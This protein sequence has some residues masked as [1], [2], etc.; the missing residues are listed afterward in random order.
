MRWQ[1]S[2][3]GIGVIQFTMAILAVCV[4]VFLAQLSG[5]SLAPL[6]AFPWRLGRGEA[7]RLLSS[8]LLHGGILHFAFNMLWFYRLNQA[9]ERWLGPWTA[10]GLFIFLAVGAGSP[11]AVFGGY[12][13]GAIGASGVV[14]GLFGFLWVCRRR[15]DI[16]AEAVTPP[17]IQTMLAWMGL[18][19]LLNFFGGN[20]ANIAH[21]FGLLFGWLIGQIVVA[22]RNVRWPLIAGTAA[23]WCLL[24]SLTYLPVWNTVTSPIPR[25]H[26]RYGWVDL[27][28]SDWRDAEE[29]L[30]RVRVGTL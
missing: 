30:G 9:I 27:D 7:W 5:T 12:S 28:E 11:Q 18:C 19:F 1:E 13:I 16:A 29:K 4:A 8:T 26:E 17:V 22:T 24:L 25:L 21:V 23:L 20:I 6:Q 3:Q 2:G 10:M 14:Y 15:Y